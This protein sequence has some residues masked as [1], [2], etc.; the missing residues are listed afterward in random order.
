MDE[1]APIRPHAHG[2]SADIVIAVREG[3]L[4]AVVAVAIGTARVEVVLISVPHQSGRGVIFPL[5][6]DLGVFRAF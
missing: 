6:I 1:A 2:Q 5:I 4:A 3:S